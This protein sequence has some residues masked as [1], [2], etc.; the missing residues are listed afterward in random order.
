[1]PGPPIILVSP[2]EAREMLTRVVRVAIEQQIRKEL[3][4]LPAQ[5]KRV[6]IARALHIQRTEER[7]FQCPHPRPPSYVPIGS[8]SV[9]RHRFRTVVGDPRRLTDTPT[10]IQAFPERSPTLAH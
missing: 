6:G 8:P 1:M 4:H 10:E 3:L 9:P 5:K 2:E 7:D